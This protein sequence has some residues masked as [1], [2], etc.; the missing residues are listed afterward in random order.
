MCLRITSSHRDPMNKKLSFHHGVFVLNLEES[1]P[2]LWTSWTC[3]LTL[4]KIGLDSLEFQLALS[5]NLT[6]PGQLYR[7]SKLEK[8]RK[9]KYYDVPVTF[10]LIIY[11]FTLA[12]SKIE[13]AK[14]SA[15]KFCKRYSLGG[16]RFLVIPRIKRDFLSSNPIS[17]QPI[18]Q[19]QICLYIS[20]SIAQV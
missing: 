16:L 9:K 18:Y 6:A 2:S 13:L 10:L 1:K 4:W 14:Q 11:M 19:F 20:I 15:P 12:F 8:R 3:Q 5:K 7:I 17:M